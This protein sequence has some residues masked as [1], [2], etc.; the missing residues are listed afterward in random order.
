LTTAYDK[1]S[2]PIYVLE[3]GIADRNHDDI[4]RQKFIVSHLRELWNSI[5]YGGADIR[6]Y[7]HWSLTDN[8]EWAEGFTARFGLISI[9]YE[10]DFERKPRLSSEIYAKII[11]SNSISSDINK[12]YSYL[13]KEAK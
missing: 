6:G 11:R 9:D 3:S 1:Y 4:R 13:R 7:M 2:K 8:F 5:N 12:K 10:N